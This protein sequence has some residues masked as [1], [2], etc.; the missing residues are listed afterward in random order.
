MSAATQSI[1]IF[2]ATGLI[3]EHITKAIVDSKKFKRIGIFT[4][5]NTVWTKSEEIAALKAQGVEVFAGNLTSPDAAKE[6]YNGFDTIVSAVGRPIIHDQ[7]KLIEWADQHPDVKRFFPSEFGTDIEYGPE[8]AQEK[9]H[10]QKL[11]VRAALKG[12]KDLDYTYVVTGPY[13]DADRGLFL[14]ARPPEEEEA[15]TFDVKRERAVLLGTGDGEISLTTMRDVGKLVVAAL[16]HPEVSKNRAL[17]VNSFT[18]T[19]KAIADEFQKQTGDRWDVKYTSLER[20]KEIEQ[21]AWENGSP[22]AGSVTLRR[23]WTEGG[24]LY[25]KRDNHLIGMEESMDTLQDAVRQ[26]IEVQ[27]KSG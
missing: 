18:A 2:G 12:A 23:I 24:T 13:A 1:L 25:D 5:N 20:L 8:S 17:R 11:K 15:G 27:R 22:G 26:A 14:S 21:E 9:P 19:P 4:S 16:L 6:A 3:G 10:Q 7:V